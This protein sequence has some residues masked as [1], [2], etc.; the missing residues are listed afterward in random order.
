MSEFRCTNLGVAAL[1]LAIGMKH[2]R[3][4]R[5]VKAVSFVFDDPLNEC[6]RAQLDYFGGCGFED[7]QRFYDSVNAVRA[8]IWPAK[9]DGVW[10]NKEV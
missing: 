7:L 5:R 4:E 10:N 9:R 3:T 2:I 1:L 6:A 8:T